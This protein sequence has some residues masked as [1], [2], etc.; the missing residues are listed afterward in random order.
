MITLGNTFEQKCQFV[1]DD[2]FYESLDTSIVDLAFGL[3]LKYLNIR[4]VN[5]MQ[6]VSKFL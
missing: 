2:D 3:D 6:K 1:L 4:G 5:G